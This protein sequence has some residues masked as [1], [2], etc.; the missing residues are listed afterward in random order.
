MAKKTIKMITFINNNR[1][2]ITEMIFEAHEDLKSCVTRMSD[3]ERR[4]MILN[5]P[6]LKAWAIS[7]GVQIA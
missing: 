6:E 5:V 1:K 7:Q 3:D 2:K 4:V